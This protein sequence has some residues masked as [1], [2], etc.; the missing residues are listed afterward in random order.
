VRPPLPSLAAVIVAAA[1]AGG[2]STASQEGAGRGA[3]RGAVGGM[4]A[5]AVGTVFWGGDAVNNALRAGAVGAASGAAVGAMDGAA[6]DREARG[7]D[8]PPPAPTQPAARPASPPAGT[9]AADPNAGLRALIGD[10]N[11]AAGEELARCRHVT[12]MSRAERAVATETVTARRGYALLIEAM[13]AEE[14]NNTARADDV[15]RRW[16]EFDPARADRN[17]ARAEALSGLQKVQR[18]RQDAGLPVL[19]T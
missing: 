1:V 15:Y 5:G 4:V 16:G 6:R 7:T 14:S 8:M 10:A 13:A 3:S 19:C 2:C 18:I 11:F 17:A 12:A 9:A